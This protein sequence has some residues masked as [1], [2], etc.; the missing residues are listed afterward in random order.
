MIWKTSTKVGLGIASDGKG[1]VYVVA[2]YN[3]AGN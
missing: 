3:P 1:G 2:R